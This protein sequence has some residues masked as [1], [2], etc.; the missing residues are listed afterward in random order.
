MKI[1][2]SLFLFFLIASNSSESLVFYSKIESHLIKSEDSIKYYSKRKRYKQAILHAK[3][4]LENSYNNHDSSKIAKANFHLGYNYRKM[5]SLEKAYFHYNNSFSVYL[6][7]GDSSSAGKK[8]LSMANIQKALG[9]FT[10][11]KETAIEG[12]TYLENSSEY[13]SIIGLY[14]IISVALKE[15]GSYKKA[16]SWNEKAVLL[17]DSKKIKNRSSV[18]YKNSRANILAKQSKYQESLLI[19]SYLL[20]DS[21]V[22]NNKT[23]HARILTNLG[24]IKWLQ[25]KGNNES[26]SELLKGLHIRKE[27]NSVSGLI[28]SNIHL[29]KYY[30]QDNPKQAL[31]FAQDALDNAKKIKNP[32]SILEALDLIVP[33][34]TKLNIGLTEEANLYSKTHNKLTQIRQKIR[35]IYA[36]TKYDNDKLTNDNLI[37]KAEKAEKE[38]I[39]TLMWMV[40]FSIIA[41]SSFFIYRKNHQK[42]RAAIESEYKAEIRMGKKV[43]DELGNDIFYLMTQIQN[44]PKLLFDNKGFVLLEGLDKVYQKARDITKKYTPIK[45]DENFGD[46]LMTML[47]SYGNNHIKVITKELETSFWSVFSRNQKL[48]LFWIVRELMTN[49]RKYSKA[50]FVGIT[51][52]KVQ[53]QLELNYTDN[54]VGFTNNPTNWGTGLKSVETRIKNLN[55][56]FSFDSAPDKGVAVKIKFPV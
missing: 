11:C 40:L 54:G 17:S 53:N 50:S 6:K 36:T 21:I 48:E 18:I 34:K 56:N 25:N 26:E 13:N 51:F 35:S 19:L 41:F 5:D 20:K 23:E 38:R 9:D 39:N 27:I 32:V 37:L 28:S 14:H 8:L 49:M 52:T 16:L 29:A 42:K 22:L 4:F 30:L 24:R 12:L 7:L 31:T 10:G 44:N 43:H 15:E 1:Y 2:I 33:L 55:G 46:E 45:T 47:N 3:V